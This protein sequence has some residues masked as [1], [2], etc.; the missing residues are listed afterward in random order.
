[1]NSAMEKFLPAVPEF[2]KIMQGSN[3]ALKKKLKDEFHAD[4]LVQRWYWCT[5]RYVPPWGNYDASVKF[6]LE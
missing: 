5:A 2:L 4:L 1:M 6:I 3:Q